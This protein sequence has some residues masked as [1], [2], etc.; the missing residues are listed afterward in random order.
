MSLTKKKLL[1]KAAIDKPHKLGQKFFGEDV[2]VKLP[3]ELKRC[4]R[5]AQM[6]DAKGNAKDSY[7]ERH[8]V[9]TIIDSVC[10]KDGKMIFSDADTEA[11]ASLD[12]MKLDAL[13]SAIQEWVDSKEK[14]EGAGSQS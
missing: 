1:E 11:I 7:R 14:N 10:D 2:Y 4:R 6:F 8:R 13:H 3:T 9:Y 12:S 5:A